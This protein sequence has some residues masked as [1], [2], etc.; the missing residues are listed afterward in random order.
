MTKLSRRNLLGGGLLSIGSIALGGCGRF[1]SSHGVDSVLGSSEELTMRVQRLAGLRSLGS[2][3][4]G[5]RHCRVVSRPLDK[6][7][8]P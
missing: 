5:C 4:K 8:T 2:L 1:F 7:V 6:S 3:R